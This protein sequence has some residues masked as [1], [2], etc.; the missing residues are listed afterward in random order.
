[1]RNCNAGY[2]SKVP[3]I[4]YL[5]CICLFWAGSALAAVKNFKVEI[6]SPNGTETYIGSYDVENGSVSFLSVLLDGESVDMPEGM[7]KELRD[8]FSGLTTAVA[9]KKIASDSEEQEKKVEMSVELLSHKGSDLQSV[10]ASKEIYVTEIT[11]KPIH[12]GVV[13]GGSLKEFKLI[14]SM[15][16]AGSC[17]NVTL[18][19]QQSFGDEACTTIKL[20]QASQLVLIFSAR[21]TER[22]GTG[23]PKGGQREDYGYELALAGV[24]GEGRAKAPR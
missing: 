13:D 17:I 24:T 9:R 3:A 6:H 21:P 22:R 7:A 8:Y 11:N 10:F 15:E 5:F 23:V 16:C 2:Q 4:L 1:M 20:S 12:V 19:Y 18:G 14:G